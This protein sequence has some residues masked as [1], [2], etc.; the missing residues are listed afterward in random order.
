M[1]S[2]TICMQ[3]QLGATEKYRGMFETQKSGNKTSS[4]EIGL[5]IRTHA[6]HKVGQGQVSG[7][8]S[9]L[10]WHAA[11]VA[12]VLWKP[13]TEFT[14]D[15]CWRHNGWIKMPTHTTMVTKEVISKL[16]FGIIECCASCSTSHLI[17]LLVILRFDLCFASS[18]NKRG[19]ST[20]WRGFSTRNAHMVH[21]VYYIRFKMVYTS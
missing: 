13:R 6:S 16:H 7:G 8:V 9:V 15:V 1:R 21:I 14:Y 2:F 19:F 10:C 3:W 5:D 20:H 11:P 4:G 12:N 17:M 18:R